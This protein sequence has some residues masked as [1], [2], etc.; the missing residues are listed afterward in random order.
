MYKDFNCIIQPISNVEMQ[1]DV[2][3]DNMMRVDLINTPEKRIKNNPKTD[4]KRL[5]MGKL[6]SDDITPD[7]LID[8]NPQIDQ[9]M[10]QLRK[11]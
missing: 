3:N 10:S 5:H 1:Q 2:P 4:V 9:L 6:P 7:Q 11:V 8:S